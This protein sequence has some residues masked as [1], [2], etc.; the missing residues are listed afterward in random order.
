MSLILRNKFLP[1]LR[2]DFFGNDF[3]PNFFDS[4]NQV[5]VP[6]VNIYENSEGFKIDLAAPGLDKSDFKI[7]I[8]NN[9]LT[10]SSEKEVK[11]EENTEKFMRKE[12]SYCSFK[13]SFALPQTA[14]TEKISATHNN[15]I[16]SVNIH[17]KDEAKEKPLR[18]I[19]IN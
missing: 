10:I 16:L 14:D 4:S 9:V 8:K 1:D 6:S 12:F 19:E 18:Q 17:K 2:D 5:S 15:G 13:R 11:N 7:E 3:F